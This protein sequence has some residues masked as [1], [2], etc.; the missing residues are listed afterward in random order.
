VP[1]IEADIKK[2]QNEIKWEPEIS[3]KDT[4]KETLEYWRGKI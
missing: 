4:L 3:L 2:L 1:I